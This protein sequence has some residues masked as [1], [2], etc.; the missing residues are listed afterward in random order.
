M[1]RDLYDIQVLGSSELTIDV[2]LCSGLN[3]NI[4]SKCGQS[5][6]IHHGGLYGRSFLKKLI[7]KAQLDAIAIVSLYCILPLVD[8]HPKW[9]NYLVTSRCL[10]AM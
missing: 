1:D 7:S 6:E 2:S 4:N 3:H 10:I 8:F 9:V 5:G